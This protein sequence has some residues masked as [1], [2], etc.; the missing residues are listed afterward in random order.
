[1]NGN[2]TSH[3]LHTYTI[4]FIHCF[5]CYN[6]YLYI[7]FLIGER[8]TRSYTY[9]NILRITR[10]SFEPSVAV[11]LFR[12][13]EDVVVLFINFPEYILTFGYNNITLLLLFLCILREHLAE[14]YTVFIIDT[15]FF[16]LFIIYSICEV[17]IP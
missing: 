6:I 14:Y 5:G 12:E 11:P 7:Y 15:A 8:S 2:M 13:T 9:Y 17:K 4:L 1:M 10:T 3:G 16:S